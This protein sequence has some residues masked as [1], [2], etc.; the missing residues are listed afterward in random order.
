MKKNT[1]TAE[2]AMTK[3]AIENAL[4][5]VRIQKKLGV[6]NYDRKQMLLGKG[7]YE[8]VYN[9]QGTKQDKYG[10]QLDATDAIKSQTAEVKALYRQH[11]KCAYLA[12]DKQRGILE[13]LQLN[14][15][16]KRDSMG[17]LEQMNTFYTKI[18]AHSEVIGRF[19]VSPEELAQA[20]AMVDALQAAHQQQLQSIGEAQD[21][22]E[23]RN[24]KRKEL[25]AWMSKFR[26]VARIALSDEPQLLE[27]LGIMVPTQKV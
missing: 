6:F 15:I 23:K 7:L 14:G 21:A 26:K 16:R 27:I 9:L 20:K 18:T 5:N 3:M 24:A 4:Q 17:L 19:N 2:M 10:E 12:F 13:Q 1:M 25:K 8:E 22:T 11:V